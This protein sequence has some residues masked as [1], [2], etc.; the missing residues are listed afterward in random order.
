[1]IQIRTTPIDITGNDQN[2]KEVADNV[3]VNDIGEVFVTN[4]EEALII[5]TE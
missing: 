1:M 2:W 4:G 5:S 3:F